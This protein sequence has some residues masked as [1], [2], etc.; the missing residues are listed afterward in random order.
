[1]AIASGPIPYEAFGAELDKLGQDFAAAPAMR[2]LDRQIREAL[3]RGIRANFMDGSG[4]DGSPW[5]P[6]KPSTI[7]RH[8]PHPLLILSGALLASATS[9]SGKGS[10]VEVTD[11]EITIG[12]K[13]PYAKAQQFG[14]SEI[15]LPPRP[16]Y[17]IPD[18][19]GAEVE[20]LLR[21]YYL[22]VLKG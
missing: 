19:I 12:V 6:H 11:N 16:Y 5:P 8:G 18:S 7:R 21:D 20:S 22:G 13:L 1:M 9:E 10:F 2:D 14:R 4:P 15:N 17:G 3:Y